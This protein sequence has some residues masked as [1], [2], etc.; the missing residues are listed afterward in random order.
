MADKKQH[1]IIENGT[2]VVGLLILLALISYLV[3]QISQDKKSP[4]EIQVT[5][6]Y[7]TAMDNY[8]FEVTVENNGGEAAEAVNIKLSL[9]QEGEAVEDGTLDIQYVPVK[10]KETGWIVF[11]SDRKTGDSLVVSSV[12]YMKP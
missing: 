9:Y 4:P 3:Y 12:T 7:L 5:T 8:A 2:F 10:S 1:N 11:H 6:N